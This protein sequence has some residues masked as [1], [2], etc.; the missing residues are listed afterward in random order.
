MLKTALNVVEKVDRAFEDQLGSDTTGKT[1]TLLQ[2]TWSILML[3]QILSNVVTTA[4]EVLDADLEGWPEG[5]LM[6]RNLKGRNWCPHLVARLTADLSIDSLYYLA[7]IDWT[8][9][10][11]PY[12]VGRGRGERT[13]PHS[14]CSYF[15]CHANNVDGANYRTRHLTEG[16]TCGEDVGPDMEQLGAILDRGEIPLLRVEQ[17]DASRG[18]KGVRVRVC[19]YASDPRP[20]Y[21]AISHIWAH[22]LG[23]PSENKLPPCQISRISE[24]AQRL[25]GRSDQAFWIDTCCVPLAVNRRRKAI[26]L[27]HD[28]YKLSSHVLVLDASLQHHSM[29]RSLWRPLDNHLDLTS[30]RTTLA[31]AT[32]LLMRIVCSSWVQRLWTLP[33]GQLP[34]SPSFA[35]SDG[36]VE[37][38]DLYYTLKL[39][40]WI[41]TSL[42]GDIRAIL[43]L[44]RPR[45]RGQGAMGQP[46]EDPPYQN[47]PSGSLHDRFVAMMQAMSW[48]DSSKAADEVP[49]IATQL[50]LD[51][52]AIMHGPEPSRMPKLLQQVGTLPLELMFTHGPRISE[53]P[54]RWA[55]QHLLGR[56]SNYTFNPSSR[57]DSE[58]GVQTDRGL[59]VAMRSFWVIKKQVQLPESPYL[60]YVTWDE[61]ATSGDDDCAVYGMFI[62]TRAPEPPPSW[63]TLS[64]VIRVDQIRGD[65]I[66]ILI[67]PAVLPSLPPS[68]P[69]R[70]G[71]M[72]QISFPTQDVQGTVGFSVRP[73]VTVGMRKMRTPDQFPEEWWVG[74]TM[75]PRFFC[76]G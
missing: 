59:F 19:S 27:M 34:P 16:C 49:C 71:L 35:F 50:G 4:Y 9:P 55:P 61:D 73:L 12:V 42:P 68:G 75:E 40:P 3:G 51:V 26:E 7:L 72:V 23:N 46:P 29:Y 32:E 66:A 39:W 54:F 58:K 57:H 70:V 17:T 45:I 21:V 41:G 11:S 24:L 44:L 37:A 10:D 8:L 62:D 33:E 5:V 48:R 69:G 76:V 74:R 56:S 18:R 28:T 38:A 60:F 63:Q 1:L 65:D 52:H 30:R 31:V 22:G 64:N 47:W 43:L 36:M 6:E 15:T 53:Y 13:N 2:V 67:G 25:T 20:D 14:E